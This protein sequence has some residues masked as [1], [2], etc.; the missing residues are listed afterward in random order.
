VPDRFSVLQG[1]SL[2]CCD[3]AAPLVEGAQHVGGPTVAFAVG[4][5]FGPDRVSLLSE[6]LTARRSRGYRGCQTRRHQVAPGAPAPVLPLASASGLVVPPDKIMAPC[7]GVKIPPRVQ[8]LR[9]AVATLARFHPGRVAASTRLPVS[10]SGLEH[11]QLQAGAHAVTGRGR[12]GNLAGGHQRLALCVWVGQERRRQ[13]G[14]RG[15]VEGRTP[16]F[17]TRSGAGCAWPVAKA[18]RR[19]A[20][21]LTTAAGARTPHAARPREVEK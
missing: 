14:G 21:R 20:V 12:V 15:V 9:C 11:P 6:P 5:A 7:D 8:P 18:A 10:L 16:M 13:E 3:Q 2:H 4:G 19:P 17:R 1:E